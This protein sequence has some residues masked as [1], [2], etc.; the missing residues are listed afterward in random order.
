MYEFFNQIVLFS[1]K[2][3]NVSE[4]IITKKK[5]LARVFARDKVRFEW[6]VLS[7][8]QPQITFLLNSQ[9]AVLYCMKRCQ[10]AYFTVTLN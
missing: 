2:G 1:Q 10:A 4:C 9:L 7:K 3:W 5:Q 6:W 8:P